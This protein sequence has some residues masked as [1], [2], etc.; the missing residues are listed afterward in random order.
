MELRW[1]VVY[2][3]DYTC[4]DSRR[5]PPCKNEDVALAEIGYSA[6]TSH[7]PIE[8]MLAFEVDVPFMIQFTVKRSRYFRCTVPVCVLLKDDI[9]VG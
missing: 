3:G 8:L 1:V 2:S 9:F 5:A 7:I 4:R 6:V